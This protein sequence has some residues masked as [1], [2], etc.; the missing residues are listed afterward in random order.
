MGPNQGEGATSAGVACPES[1]NREPL[2]E[3][4][5]FILLETGNGCGHLAPHAGRRQEPNDDIDRR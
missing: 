1:A 5:N 4:F 3:A 2:P